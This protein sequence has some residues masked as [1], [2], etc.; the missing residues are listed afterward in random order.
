MLVATDVAA[1]GIHVDDVD[2]VVHFDP[3]N[4]HKDYLHRSG[5][6]ARAGAT[7]TVVSLVD[8]AQARDVARMHDAAGLTATRNDVQAGHDVVRQ[9]ATSGTPF[10]PAAVPSRPPAAPQQSPRRTGRSGAG[11]SGAGRSGAGR[12]G[13]SR[14]GARSYGAG[15]PGTSFRGQPQPAAGRPAA[16]GWPALA[17]ARG[18]RRPPRIGSTRPEQLKRDPEVAVRPD[19]YASCSVGRTISSLMITRCGLVT[20]NPMISAMSAACSR[21]MSPN[22]RFI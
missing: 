18:I 19:R 3:P 4:D 11:R 14:P 22:R 2:L 21:L 17:A 5:R 9:I 1:R 8:P 12:S 6:T 13:T 15:Q 7:G 16:S 20:M 10:Q